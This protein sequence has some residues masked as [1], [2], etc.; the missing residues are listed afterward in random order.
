MTVLHKKGFHGYRDGD[1]RSPDPS[2]PLGQPIDLLDPRKR[3][4]GGAGDMVTSITTR[5]RSS[6]RWR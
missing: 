4:D 5:P 3:S 6:T 1:L 2:E